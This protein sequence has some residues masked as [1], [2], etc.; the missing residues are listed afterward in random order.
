[1]LGPRAVL[2][3]WAGWL[4]VGVGCSAQSVPQPARVERARV[5]R[6]AVLEGE[7]NAGAR[8]VQPLA[9]GLQ[10][11]LDPLGW[12]SGWLLR[13]EPVGHTSLQHDNANLA[14]PPYDSVNPLLLSTDF[15]FRA[16]DVVAWNPRS[17]RYAPDAASYRQL[18]TLYARYQQSQGNDAQAAGQLAEVV[19]RLPAGR[20]EILDAK[21]TPGMANQAQMAAAVASHF[22]TTAHTVVLPQT[23]QATPLG[24]VNW[25]RFRVVVALP[26]AMQP[27]PNVKLQRGPCE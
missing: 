25:L 10:V 16:Q 13:V 15:S 9:G 17:F 8:F 11:E 1:M 24:R 22:S 2:A 7:V 23:G 18:A 5:C 21:L 12:G 3:G 27:G 26:G 14:T 19:S 20:L 6:L 4:V